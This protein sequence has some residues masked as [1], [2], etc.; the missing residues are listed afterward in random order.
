MRA[1]LL[2]LL[3]AACVLATGCGAADDKQADTSATPPAGATS[4]AP[5]SSTTTVTSPRATAA[6]APR[7]TATG[8]DATVRGYFKAIAGRDGT[9]ACSLLT[10]GA[11][12]QAIATVQASQKKRYASCAQALVAAV[13]KTSSATLRSVYI[14]VTKSVVKGDQ[15][16]VAVKG[17]VRDIDLR[18]MGKRWY[19]EDGIG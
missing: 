14:E 18:R 19:I 1:G 4:T 10:T 17:G 7:S 2:S 9:T 11:R 12:R 6:T 5:E 8:P 16:T 3:V 15:A 13:A